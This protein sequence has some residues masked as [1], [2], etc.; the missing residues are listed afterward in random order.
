[1]RVVEDSITDLIQVKYSLKMEEIKVQIFHVIEKSFIDVVRQ[2]LFIKLLLQIFGEPWESK[3]FMNALGQCN[4][5][6]RA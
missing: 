2:F 6:G 5:D 3:C 1:M 4:V